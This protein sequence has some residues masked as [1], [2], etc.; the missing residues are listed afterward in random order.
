MANRSDS[1]SVLPRRYKRLIAL[2]TDLTTEAR[3]REVRMLFV[4]ANAHAQ[5]VR[6]AM[7]TQKGP[8]DREPR[9]QPVSDSPAT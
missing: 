9:E 2:A 6:K 3:R 5:G 7:L 4:K 8:V 1:N